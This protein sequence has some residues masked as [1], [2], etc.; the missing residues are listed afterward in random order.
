[1]YIFSAKQTGEPPHFSVQ[2]TELSLQLDNM[3][4]SSACSS[5]L[6]TLA[7]DFERAMELERQQAEL[8]QKNF[9]SQTRGESRNAAFEVPGG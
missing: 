8:D 5:G 9:E 3:L 6:S 7:P 2:V 4:S 1:M